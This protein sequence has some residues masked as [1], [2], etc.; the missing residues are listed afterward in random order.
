MSPRILIGSSY[1]R[2]K[3]GNDS[4]EFLRIWIL[5]TLRVLHPSV[6]SVKIVC[7]A[8][9]VFP[10]HLRSPL[11]EPIHLTGDLGHVSHLENGTKPYEFCGWTAGMIALAMLAYC[12]ESDFVYKESDALAFGPWLET[13][14][15]DLGD[16]DI[17]FGHAQPVSPC[18][19]SSQSIFI[20]R[21][22]FIPTFVSKYLS[23]GGDAKVFGEHKFVQLEY[24]F[25]KE[26]V[27]RLSFGV[28]RCR[29]IPYSDPVF[30]AQQLY[31]EEMAEL[32]KRA[33]I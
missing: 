6:K 13:G 26:R 30:Y 14:Y 21:H 22:R 3:Q 7:E 18:M 15:K 25:G 20:V 9:T 32:R 31:P 28:D 17:V 4:E 8:G 27:K 24:E 23:Y 11:I 33:L 19:P 12:D 5:N 1:F 29:P 10:A 16:G 2:N